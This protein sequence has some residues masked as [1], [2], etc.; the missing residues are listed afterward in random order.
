MEPANEDSGKTPVNCDVMTAEGVDAGKLCDIRRCQGRRCR[1]ADG[2]LSLRQ[3]MKSEMHPLDDVRPLDE[4][5]PL[6]DGRAAYRVR[7]DVV[8]FVQNDIT[9]VA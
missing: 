1:S 7:C 2:M 3:P 8:R 5:R 9:P 4:V 6:D